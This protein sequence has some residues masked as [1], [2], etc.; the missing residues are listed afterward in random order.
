MTALFSDV[1][2]TGRGLLDGWRSAR[3]DTSP[4]RPVKRFIHIRK[5]VCVNAALLVVINSQRLYC[6]TFDELLRDLR[7]KARWRP[8]VEESTPPQ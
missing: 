4:Q 8:W 3:Y 1:Y 5:K 2:G 6:C 7:W